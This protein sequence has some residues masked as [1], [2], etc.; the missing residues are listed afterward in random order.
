MTN[1]RE[2]NTSDMRIDKTDWSLNCSTSGFGMTVGEDQW[3]Y[4]AGGLDSKG[5]L[6]KKV[7]R[8]KRNGQKESLSD[9]RQAK[10]DFSLVYA[11]K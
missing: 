3:I 9:L 7:H 1:V 11:P 10:K 4:I 8:F 2:L 6:Q 5:K